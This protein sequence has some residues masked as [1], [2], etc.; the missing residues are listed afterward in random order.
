MRNQCVDRPRPMRDR[1]L[2]GQRHLH[3]DLRGDDADR[4]ERGLSSG[5]GGRRTGC[6]SPRAEGTLIT[7]SRVAAGGKPWLDPKSSSPAVRDSSG[8]TSPTPWWARR[9]SSRSII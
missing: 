4:E 2:L 5:E 8:A 9:T 6:A 1:V 3:E 7:S